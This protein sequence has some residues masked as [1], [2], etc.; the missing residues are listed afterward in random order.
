LENEGKKQTRIILKMATYYNSIFKNKAIYLG[1][2]SSLILLIANSQII[3]AIS[4]NPN[5]GVPV[6][7][8]GI[9]TTAE[10]SFSQ[11]L[12]DGDFIL[13]WRTEGSIISFGIEGNTNGWVSIGISPTAMMRNADMYFGWVTS[14][15]SVVVIDAY[16]TGLT[17]P[18][19]ADIDLGGTND[20]IAYNGSENGQTTTI[21]FS[22]FL[23]TTDSDHD[24]PLPQTGNIKMI[25]ALGSSDSFDAA[26]V[27]RGSLQ[28]NLEGASAF[29]A[30]FIQPIILGLSLF[31]TLS[32][33]VIFVD[34]KSR[35]A[36][37]KTEP[38]GEDEEGTW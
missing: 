20:V 17:G 14:S 29:N 6:V 30:D 16:A 33:L 5:Q 18:H 15:G 24:N 32:G 10:Y 2:I 19:P 23:V 31:I 34:S 36:R 25:W 26:H 27:K 12:S 9:I 13:H 38:K 22:R 35:S 21:E 1:F 37:R 3:S 4:A 11:V 28:W 7:I 8:D